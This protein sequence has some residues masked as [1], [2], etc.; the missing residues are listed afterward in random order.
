MASNVDDGETNG[1]DAA[2]DAEE[3]STPGNWLGRWV[4]IVSILAFL[5]VYVSQL[6]QGSGLLFAIL[7]S[8]GAMGVVGFGGMLVRRI[9][10]RTASS[11]RAARILEQ[12]RDMT[13][14]RAGDTNANA[15]E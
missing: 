2:R 12:M 15:D 13:E 11:E 3:R 10:L 4:L 6:A 7:L 9:L 5:V 8:A 14:A 1:D